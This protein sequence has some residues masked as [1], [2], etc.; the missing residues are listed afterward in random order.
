VLLPWVSTV[1]LLFGTWWSPEAGL[2]SLFWWDVQTVHIFLTHIR[3]CIYFVL[4]CILRD[5]FDKKKT[6]RFIMWCLIQILSIRA[7][8]QTIIVG[9]CRVVTRNLKKTI[10][11]GRKLFYIVPSFELNVKHKNRPCKYYI[12]HTALVLL[13]VYVR[14]RFC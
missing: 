12:P 4:I 9:I 11:L 8:L 1:F 13:Q 7:K 5:E 2:N 3:V 14:L 6:W 10:T